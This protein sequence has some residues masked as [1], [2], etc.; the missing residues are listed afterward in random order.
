MRDIQLFQPDIKEEDF[1]EGLNYWNDGVSRIEKLE[2][3]FKKE[4]NVKNV[5][6]TTNGTSALHLCLCALEIKRGDKILC[7]VNAHPMI[8]EVIR[9]F[10]AE[11]IFVDIDEESYNMDMNACE[12]VLQARYTKKLRGMI[13]TH[14]GGQAADLEKAHELK[15]KYGLFLIEDVTS[16]CGGTY[17]NKPLGSA[18]GDVAIFSLFPEIENMPANGGILATNDDELAKKASLLR[19]H[20]QVQDTSGI[21]DYIYDIVDIGC[22]YDIS[23]IDAAFYFSNLKRRDANIA[24]RKEIAAMYNKGLDATPHVKIPSV[25]NDHIY[26]MYIIKID[27]NR[28]SFAKELAELGIGT[29]LNYIPLHLLSYYKTKYQLKVNNFPAA[30]R[31][32]QQILSLPIH[33]KVTNEEVHYIIDTIKKIAQKRV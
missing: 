27:K 19:F 2:N 3:F 18:Y 23:E 4:L 14:L 11:P 25:K 20:A 7:S 22:R 26:T 33:S 16:G 12:K 1:K 28:D 13:L 17:K 32:Y 30:L 31:N 29:G 24:R 21:L 6:S 9:H 15:K 8:P 5:I 10:D